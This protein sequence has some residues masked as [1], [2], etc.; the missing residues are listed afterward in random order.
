MKVAITE[1]GNVRPVMMVERQLCRNR[2]TISTVSAAPS[3]MVR[4]TLS[5]ESLMPSAFDQISRISTSVGS[6]LARS[7][8]ATSMPLPTSMM[9]L[10]CTL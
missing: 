5:S 10:P 6:R 2:N 1:I 9:L 3:K 8:R 7:A 4:L